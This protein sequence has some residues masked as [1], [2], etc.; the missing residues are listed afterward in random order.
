MPVYKY[1]VKTGATEKDKVRYMVKVN[2]RDLQHTRRGFLTKKHAEAYDRR[3]KEQMLI[4]VVPRSI[5]LAQVSE[6]WLKHH[7][8]EVKESTY[9]DY[10]TLLDKHILPALGHYKLDDITAMQVQE[11]LGNIKDT[12]KGRK[13]D[14]VG[15]RTRDKVRMTLGA[16]YRQARAW[17]L[18]INNPV[19][20]TRTPPYKRERTIVFLEPAQAQPFLDALEEPIKTMAFLLLSTGMRS[21]EAAALRWVDVNP[22]FINVDKS[23]YKGVLTDPKTYKGIRRVKITP[24]VYARLKA[25][26]GSKGDADLVFSLDGG[27]IPHHYIYRRVRAAGRAAGMDRLGVHDLRHTYAAWM[28]SEGFNLRFIMEQM[29]HSDVQVLLNTYGHIISSVEADYVVRFDRFLH[30]IVR[31]SG[32]A[33]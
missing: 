10:R 2:T 8:D 20:G 13:D 16:V 24:E 33:Q 25:Y 15:P 5:T 9:R 3:I 12:H 32:H 28:I 30:Q 26:R 1:K 31:F 19:E 18:T 29:G 21:G 11:F 23:F 4:G 27:Y 22:S 7:R 17:G 6:K 14:P